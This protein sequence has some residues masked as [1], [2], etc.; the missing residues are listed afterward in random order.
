MNAQV[1]ANIL[2]L[3]S[4]LLYTLSTCFKSKKS[5][6]LTQ[7]GESLVGSIAQLVIGSYA[8]ATT[9]VVCSV[10]NYIFSKKDQSILLSWIFCIFFLTFGILINNQ[11]FIGLLPVCATI[12][13]T[14]WTGYIKDPQVIRYGTIINTIP[15][16]IHD[17]YMGLYVSV[18][19]MCI[20][21]VII[22]IN[23]IRYKN[24]QK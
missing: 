11:G 23:I 22:T 10:R 5:I 7:T 3:V 2:S 24:K 16:I 20:S 18:I 13:Y 1:I 17:F 19:T 14:L 4:S 12:Q 15:W 21:L 9:L 8:P 6:L